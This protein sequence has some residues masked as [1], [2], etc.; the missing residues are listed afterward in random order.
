MWELTPNELLLPAAADLATGRDPVLSRA[1]AIL[2]VQL[3][4]EKAGSLFS[5]QRSN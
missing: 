3:S 4:S 2:G 5:L 1:A